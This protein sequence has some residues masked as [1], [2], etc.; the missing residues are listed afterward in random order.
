MDPQLPAFPLSRLLVKAP[1]FPEPS[2][3]PDYIRFRREPYDYKSMEIEFLEID[4]LRRDRQGRIYDVDYD[5][6][7]NWLSAKG[8]E[9]THILDLCLDAAWNFY[10][11][12]YSVAEDRFVIPRGE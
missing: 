4:D 5:G 9:V 12:I 3:K 2:I 8:V 7:K 10:H 6:L 1:G 11:A